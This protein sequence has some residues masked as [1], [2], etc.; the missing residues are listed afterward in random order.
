MCVLRASGSV[1]AVTALRRL[2]CVACSPVWHMW[3][4]IQLYA[5]L[6]YGFESSPKGFQDYTMVCSHA[7]GPTA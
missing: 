2:L 6:P 3:V 5:A 1:T 4:Q 7:P